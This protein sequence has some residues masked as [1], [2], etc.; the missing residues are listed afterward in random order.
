MPIHAAIAAKVLTPPWD[1]L[2]PR[3]ELQV[4]AALLC[5]TPTSCGPS[6]RERV[7]VGAVWGGLAGVSS[8]AEVLRRKH[9]WGFQIGANVTEKEEQECRR[10]RS[11]SVLG[12]STALPR[13]RRASASDG[14]TAALWG[15]R[16][17][18]G[19]ARDGFCRPLRRRRRR[20]AC[21]NAV[22]E[23]DLDEELDDDLRGLAVKALDAEGVK[24]S[25]LLRRV[26]K[27]CR[28]RRRGLSSAVMLFGD[29]RRRLGLRG[30]SGRGEAASA[31]EDDDRF[32]SCLDL[33]RG[34]S[35]AAERR[36]RRA[37]V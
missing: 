5:S 27:R 16:Q 36:A 20:G 14:G 34:G 32:K 8:L 9:H 37:A 4:G 28:R 15:A 24:R 1:E 30:A 22:R 23:P 6:T 25:S 7:L 3:V 18:H 33:I 11:T 2:A 29:G 35:L 31:S 10:R 19:R 13:S 21:L 26:A 17:D 12:R